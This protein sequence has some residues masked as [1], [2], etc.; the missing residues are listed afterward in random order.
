MLKKTQV[1]TNTRVRVDY[2]V[3]SGNVENI[4]S[5][6]VRRSSGLLACADADLAVPSIVL[7]MAV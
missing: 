5:K 1:M 4:Y 2:F 7:G 3:F 6:E